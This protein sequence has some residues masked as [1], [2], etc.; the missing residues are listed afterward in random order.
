MMSQLYKTGA[1]ELL[2]KS[3]LFDFLQEQNKILFGIH[4]KNAWL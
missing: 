4:N 1:V 3:H 2:K